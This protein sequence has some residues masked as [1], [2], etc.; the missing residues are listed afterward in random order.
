MGCRLETE[1][2]GG[3]QVWSD[4]GWDHCRAVRDAVMGLR[5]HRGGTERQN[6]KDRGE[7]GENFSQS[8]HHPIPETLPRSLTPACSTLRGFHR[9]HPKPF[10]EPTVGLFSIYCLSIM[11]QALSYWHGGEFRDKE[12]TDPTFQ[13]Q[14]MSPY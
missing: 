8:L 5:G 14:T 2:Q 13:K 9:L 6:I 1:T 11:L 12:G 3:F 7:G 4:G 10:S